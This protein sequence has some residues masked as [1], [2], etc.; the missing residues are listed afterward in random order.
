MGFDTSCSASKKPTAEISSKRS[1]SSI[2]ILEGDES[3]LTPLSL[4]VP[5][6]AFELSR[7]FENGTGASNKAPTPPLKKPSSSSS[8]SKGT[9][10]NTL[11][12]LLRANSGDLT[13]CWISLLIL[14]KPS[15]I[16][17]SGHR[18]N[19]KR[20]PERLGFRAWGTWV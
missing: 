13:L 16:P 20:A 4:D 11:L 1:A 9:L 5:R 8:S 14:P 12:S 3:A 7:C 10:P 19:G 18:P 2:A 17:E 6:D 15:L